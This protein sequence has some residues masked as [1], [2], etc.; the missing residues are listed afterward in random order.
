MARVENQQSTSEISVA[1]H[2][3]FITRFIKMLCQKVHFEAAG[4]PTDRSAATD[5]AYLQM[6]G[7]VVQHT[8][9]V[10]YTTG[11]SQLELK[12]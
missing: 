9:M 5:N 2:V 1:I 6:H 11:S 12:Y 4:D 10:R 7:T 8:S 3:D